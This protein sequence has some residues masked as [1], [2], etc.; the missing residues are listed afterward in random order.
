MQL[1][2]EKKNELQKRRNYKPFKNRFEMGYDD[3]KHCCHIENRL[4]MLIIDVS[5]YRM[6]IFIV[7]NG[8]YLGARYLWHYY[9]CDKIEPI[10]HYY[11]DMFKYG[12]KKRKLCLDIQNFNNLQQRLLEYDDMCLVCRS[13][14][15][16]NEMIITDCGHAYGRACLEPWIEVRNSINDF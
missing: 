1:F 13:T 9:L 5:I 14:H 10:Y 11:A 12:R 6:S 16:L 7:L 2:D 8:L 4:K 3:Y 15:E